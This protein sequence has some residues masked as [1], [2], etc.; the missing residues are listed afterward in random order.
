MPRSNGAGISAFAVYLTQYQQLPF[1]RTAELLAALAGIA[2]SPGTLY[3]MV[4]E[5]AARLAAPVAAIGQAVAQS[6]VAH[7]DETGLRVGRALQWLHVLC[8]ATLTFYAVHAKR[9]HEALEAI[10]LLASFR[11]ILVHDH[12]KAYLMY[13]CQ[14]AFCNAHHLRELI[15]VAETYP[16]LAWPERLIA[17]LCEANVATHYARAAGYAALPG[18][19]ID[20]FFTR[21]DALLAQGARA[22]PRRTGP[23]GS[24]RRVKQTPACNL[25]GRLRDHRHAVLLFIVDL[26]VP[27]DNNLA[28]RAMRMPKLKQKVSG[29]FRS[30]EGAAAF[31][32]IRSYLS[33]L[34]KQSV[35]TYQALVMT[36]QGNP[37][38]PRLP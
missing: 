9:G 13:A 35:D 26:R 4:R 18:P 25:V 1:K 36:F 16:K 30:A 37:P 5:A 23:P 31:A 32:T 34:N 8:T 29:C 7:A 21:Y 28:E 17:L 6:A 12:W 19:M 11:G 33:T 10:G 38:M 14:H 24:R 2:L 22:H 15:A 20:D 27:F 3:T